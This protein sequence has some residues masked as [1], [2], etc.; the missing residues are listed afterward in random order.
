MLTDIFR[1]DGDG[2]AIH[3]AGIVGD[4]FDQTLQYGMQTTRPDVLGGFVDLPRGL[5]DTLDAI[6]RELDIDAFGAV[7]MRSKS[8]VV[9]AVSS[10]RIG[11]RPGSSGIKSDGLATWNAP[12]AINRI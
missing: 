5:S 10:T 2:L 9:S 4:V 6:F 7:R 12:E 11:R 1:I 8:W 3:F